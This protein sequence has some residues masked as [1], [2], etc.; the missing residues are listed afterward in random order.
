MNLTY[1]IHRV[2]DIQQYRFCRLYKTQP[3]AATFTVVCDQQGY[4]ND[5]I[6]YTRRAGPRRL[7]T[8]VSNPICRMKL[9][10]SE[11]CN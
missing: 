8:L 7:F 11:I 1:E 10:L 3:Y 9:V 2:N 4:V 5:L 6:A